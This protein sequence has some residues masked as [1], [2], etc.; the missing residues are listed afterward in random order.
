MEVAKSLPG[1]TAGYGP[2]KPRRF[3][4]T[5]YLFI[6]PA[7]LVLV[8]VVILPILYSFFISFFR[9]Q[10][11]A[12]QLGARFVGLE[13]YAALFSDQ[14]LIESALWTAQFTV[15]VVSLELVLGMGMALV[16]HSRLL[17]RFRNLFRGVLLIPIMLSAVVSAWMWR[18][19]FDT[20]Y[21]PVNHLLSLIGIG[22]IPWGADSLSARAM[23]IIAD[24]W[25]ATP[26]VMLILLAGLQNI[27]EELLEAASIDG[28]TL[29]QRF[30]RIVI[31]LL[32][33]PIMIVLVI[34]TMDALRAFDQAFV[35][36]SGGPGNATSTIIFYNYR[37]AFYYFQVGR[38][39]AV[40]FAFL[41]IILA[42]T[43][44][45][46]HLLRREAD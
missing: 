41:L 11:N 7:V 32:K 27:P 1:A 8:V 12:P 3:N 9:Y 22:P 36:T 38:A 23:L 31:P 13:N 10:L 16:L 17:G 15:T 6:A 26:F 30:T 29:W 28:A 33:F 42:I 19:L 25:L 5:P 37:Y 34:R 20:T 43:A 39:A 35:L 44:I 46:T 18:L 2:K 45:Y 14:E 40:A 4:Y 24:V 21:G